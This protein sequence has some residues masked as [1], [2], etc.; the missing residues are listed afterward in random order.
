M[1]TNFKIFKRKN[2]KTDKQIPNYNNEEYENF[3]KENGGIE[4]IISKI[5]N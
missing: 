2:I 4:N 1:I 3:V 5:K